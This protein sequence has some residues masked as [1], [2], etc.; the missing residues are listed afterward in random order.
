MEKI[1]ISSMVMMRSCTGL[2]LPRTAPKEIRTVAVLK[3][4]F[5]ILQ[6]R[7]A[8]KV[9]QVTSSFYFYRKQSLVEKS[10]TL[11][12]VDFDLAV[13]HVPEALHEEAP[14]QAEGSQEQVDAHAA[15]PV[16]LQEGH[17]EA[18]ADEDHDVNVLKHCR[19]E[20]EVS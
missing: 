9:Q 4:A 14:L 7:K 15:E 17:E 13:L 19:S 12:D 5:I 3:S 16:S 1:V 10:D 8:I 20:R 18:E 11:E 6:E 2:V